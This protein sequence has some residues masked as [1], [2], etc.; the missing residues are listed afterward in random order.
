MQLTEQEVVRR[1]TLQKIIDLGINPFPAEKFDV[2]FKTTDFTTENFKANLSAQ[3]GQIKALSVSRLA[4]L[5]SAS[6][7][8]SNWPRRLKRYPRLV[9]ARD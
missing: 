3:L 1:E 2:N 9:N 5:R 6:S 8:S 4:A 7:A